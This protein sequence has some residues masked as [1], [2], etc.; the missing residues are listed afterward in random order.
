M[1]LRHVYIEKELITL[2]CFCGRAF[3]LTRRTTIVHKCRSFR[4]FSPYR[5]DLGSSCGVTTIFKGVYALVRQ[6]KMP[7]TGLASIPIDTL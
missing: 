6:C 7:L 2:G 5:H 3:L 1:Y 4:I